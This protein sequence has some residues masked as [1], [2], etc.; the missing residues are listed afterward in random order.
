MSV[1]NE[2]YGV[3]GLGVNLDNEADSAVA[4]YMAAMAPIKVETGIVELIQTRSKS[5]S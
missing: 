4:N 3:V 1:N 5:G 2:L